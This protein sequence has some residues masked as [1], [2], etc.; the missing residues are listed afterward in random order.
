MT[1]AFCVVQDVR[2][3]LEL[4]AGG[5]SKYPD[6]LVQSNIYA[7]SAFLEK[8]TRRY[9]ADRTFTV[10]APWKTTTEG[11]ASVP[12][13]GFR[14]VTSVTM[15][16][17]ALAADSTYYLLPDAQQTGIYTAIQFR[18]FTNGFGTGYGIQANSEWFDR[19][20]D[21]PDFRVRAGYGMSSIPN[22]LQIAGSA[23]YA[24]PAAS[25]PF[26][27]HATKFL[28]AHYTLHPQA[29]LAGAQ[30]TPEGAIFDVSSLPDEVSAF[31]R[32]Y[33]LGMQMVVSA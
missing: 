3:V 14:S 31:I 19:G 9:F 7:A 11:A 8:A 24:D 25:V 10:G 29:L 2:D 16:G 30:S 33:T 5:S 27:P 17:T 21:L 4:N 26:L 6:A 18:N 22:D 13:P 20:L 28:A 23:G 1:T 32:E 15:A 12:L